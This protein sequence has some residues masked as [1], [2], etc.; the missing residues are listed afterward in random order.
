MDLR[1]ECEACNGLR[2][3]KRLKDV[4]CSEFETEMQAAKLEYERLQGLFKDV[5]WY[6]FETQCRYW[7]RPWPLSL[8]G[9][10]IELN[11]ICIETCVRNGREREIGTFPIYYSGAVEHAP[12]LPPVVIFNELRIAAEYLQFCR[13]NCTAPHDW[14]P[15]GRKYVQLL[16]TTMVPTDLIKK[17]KRAEEIAAS[18]SKRVSSRK[19]E[20]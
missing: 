16:H 7:Q 15:G 13:D 10:P 18:I 4:M 9:S 2:G 6:Y 5:C 8:P 11:G 14:A 17:R 1:D 3:H 20:R 19:D 12:Q